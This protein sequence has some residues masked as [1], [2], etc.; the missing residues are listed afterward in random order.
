MKNVLYIGRFQPFHKGHA[1]AILQIFAKYPEI[2]KLYIGIGS[3][4][5][6]FLIKNP[7][8]AGERMH[9]IEEA[10]K[11]L[12]IPTEKWAIV[13]IRNIDHYDLWA[14]HVQQYLPQIDILASGSEIVQT[15][16]KK[17]FPKTEIFSIVKNKLLCATHVRE[18]IKNHTPLQEYL[19]DSSINILSQWDIAT[20][21]R[22]LSEME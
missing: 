1:D 14:Y 18:K 8:T 21:I 16:W 15:I 5:N 13:P 9:I 17:A 12:K 6:N 3:A 4:E 2:K 10:M 22:I 19:L 20:R 11:E 7:L